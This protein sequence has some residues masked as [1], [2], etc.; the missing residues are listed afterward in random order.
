MKKTALL[1]AFLPLFSSASVDMIRIPLEIF[2]RKPQTDFTAIT[3]SDEALK[4][5]LVNY[6]FDHDLLNHEGTKAFATD[7]KFDAYYAIFESRYML[8][9]LNRDEIPELIFSGYVSK[10]DEREHTEIYSTKNDIPKKIYDE[11]GHI[12]AYTIQPNTKEVLL[13][14]HQYPCCL[15]A[16]HNLNRLRFVDGN[17]QLLKRY[18]IARKAGDM[19][20]TFFPSVSHFTAK[21]K[22]LKKPAELRWAGE[23]ITKDAWFGRSQENTIGHYDIGTVYRILAEEKGWYFVLMKSPMKLETGGKVVNPAN[24]QETAVYGWIRK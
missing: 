20:G 23:K 11:L 17:L 12:P 7:A 8:I 19:K 15:N 4:R 13:Y 14:H 24:L 16:S 6:L 1:L 22:T 10:D 5:K 9:D 2:I 18:F 3:L 21:Y